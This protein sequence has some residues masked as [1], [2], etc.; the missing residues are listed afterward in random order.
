MTERTIIRVRDL[1]VGFGE[2]T[3]LDRVSVEVTLGTRPENP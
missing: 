1:V 2:R 3:V